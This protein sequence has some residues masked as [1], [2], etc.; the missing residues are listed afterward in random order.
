MKEL[1]RETKEFVFNGSIKFAFEIYDSEVDSEYTDFTVIEKGY[2][3][4]YR[5]FKPVTILLYAEKEE[6]DEKLLSSIREE[7][8]YYLWNLNGDLC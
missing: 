4:F 6:T 7:N 8:S 3:M 1:D 5:K 2:L